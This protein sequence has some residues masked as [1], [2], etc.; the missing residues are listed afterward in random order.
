MKEI[1]GY[2]GKYAICKNGDVVNL[3]FNKKLKPQF[4]YSGYLHVVLYKNRQ[5]RTFSLHRL[6]A[7]TYIPNYLNK[8]QVNHIDGN[9]TNNNV[10]NLEWVT[11]SENQKHA[12]KFL[13]KK[14]RFKRL[15]NNIT[16]QIYESVEEAAILNNVKRTTLS[17]MLIGQN[18]NKL[19]ITYTN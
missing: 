19:N 16:G 11:A 17:A 13:N 10:S 2:E 6:V 3:R 9:K 8:P 12:Y 1:K 14:R 7:N 5:A 4:N 18:K 15:I